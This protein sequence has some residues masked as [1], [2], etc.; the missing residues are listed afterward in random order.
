MFNNRI[1]SFMQMLHVHY[2]WFVKFQQQLLLE[3]C[4]YKN[5][6][7]QTVDIRYTDVYGRCKDLKIIGNRRKITRSHRY[8]DIKI[9][10]TM[11]HAFIDRGV[12]Y[13]TSI[14]VVL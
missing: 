5:A 11:M 10:C 13:P 4:T 7:K 14:G 1:G 3:T 12:R 9:Y 6:A 8:N 2:K